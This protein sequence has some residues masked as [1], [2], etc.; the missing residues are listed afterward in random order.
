MSNRRFPVLS[1]VPAII[2]FRG[3]V[4]L[5]WVLLLALPMIASADTYS[6]LDYKVQA[7]ADYGP[8]FDYMFFDLPVGYRAESVEAV[9]KLNN[10]G[11]SNSGIASIL[12]DPENGHIRAEVWANNTSEY[13]PHLGFWVWRLNGFAAAFVNLADV[14]HFTLP[15][16]NYVDPPLVRI[17]GHATYDLS[18]SGY[19]MTSGD[20]QVSVDQG[21]GNRWWQTAGPTSISHRWPSSGY[22]TNGQLD[23]V[24]PFELGVYLLA[25]NTLLNESRVVDL[26][27]DMMIGADPIK[28]GLATDQ[29]PVPGNYSYGAASI[30]VT[31]DIM[32][33]PAGV[34]L[35]SSS[36]LMLA[37][38][39][40]VPEPETWALLL[41]GLGLVGW[42]ACRRTRYLN[43]TATGAKP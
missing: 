26:R 34:S 8:S 36:G 37:N 14:L 15:A 7:Y 30:G 23:D 38:V 17:V 28:A 39:H 20:F 42:K 18:A 10:D 6:R 24:Y 5:A 12:A 31:I 43:T 27:L 21:P 9:G 3:L 32:Y 4:Y 33:L 13:D 41:T 25:P 22:L 16:G 35:T 1:P 40:L 29:P 11:L 2:I 19:Y